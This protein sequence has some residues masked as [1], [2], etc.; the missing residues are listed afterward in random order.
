MMNNVMVRNYK[1]EK[2]YLYEKKNLF[3]NIVYYLS[4]RML[5]QWMDFYMVL[6]L[7]YFCVLRLQSSSVVGRYSCFPVEA[8][9]S[10]LF[11][12]LTRNDRFQQQAS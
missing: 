6:W 10:F 1:S 3:R 9:P 7:L 12:V 4:E 11:L 5:E 2:S 8:H